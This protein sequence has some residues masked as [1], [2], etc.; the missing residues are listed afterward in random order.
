MDP[1]QRERRK[2]VIVLSPN[3]AI[4]LDAGA[5]GQVLTTQVSYMTNNFTLSPNPGRVNRSS[6]GTSFNIVTATINTLVVATCSIRNT[7]ATTAASVTIQHTTDGGLNGVTLISLSLPAK[8]TL[9]FTDSNG[10]VLTDNTGSVVT[11][12]VYPGAFYVTTSF[13]QP[14]VTGING[15]ATTVSASFATTSGMVAGMNLFGQDSTGKGGTYQVQS[16]TNATTAVLINLGGP[17]ATVSGGSV[18]AMNVYL[19][20]PV[21]PSFMSRL[22]GSGTDGILTPGAS[23][24]TVLAREFNY[25]EIADYPGG[26]TAKF[27]WSTT[28]YILRVSG[29]LSFTNSTTGINFYTVH[30]GGFA[31]AG[32][33]P[34]AG[35]TLGAG[36]LGNMAGKGGGA[37]GATNGSNSTAQPAAFGSGATTLPGGTGGT[38]ANTAGTAG[39]IGALTATNVGGSAL[40]SDTWYLFG[41]IMSNGGMGGS[42]GGGGP[43]DG[44]HAG[45]GGG[46]GAQGS[47]QIGVFASEVWLSGSSST[48]FCFGT[49]GGIGGAGGVPAAGNAGGG[50]GGAGAGAGPSTL[51]FFHYQ[52]GSA[53]IQINSTGGAGGAGGN[54]LGTGGGGTGGGG[55]SSGRTTKWDMGKGTIVESTNGG[56]GSAASAPSG[57]TGSAG[58]A[59]GSATTL[60]LSGSS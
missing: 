19:A 38:S 35:G 58:G 1:D 11:N 18:A 10:W 39:A 23:G 21:A 51:G 43:G 30:G 27:K 12:T 53:S 55:G 5:G 13:T 25:S 40:G 32:A 9:T 31:A 8:Y 56:T 50:G 2:D 6:S 54:G 14:K 45:G 46:G 7:D 37:G 17:G 44:S 60:V 15:S 57:I 41:A 42:G 3:D 28:M 59:G 29:R 48:F 33:T 16:V 49:N 47:T 34:G 22:V 20:S 4:L 26:S 52:L 36:R 24:A